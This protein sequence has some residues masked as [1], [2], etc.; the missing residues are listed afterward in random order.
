MT[1]TIVDQ[2]AEKLWMRIVAGELPAGARLRQDE[3]AA[4]FGSSHVPVRE[5]FRRLEAD[6]LVVSEPRRGV[7]VA[8]SDRA[9]HF[10]TLEMRAVLEGLAL[11]HA[12]TEYSPQDFSAVS[13]ADAACGRATTAEEWEEANRR[14]HVLLIAPCPLPALLRTVRR[15][16]MMSAL[17]ARALGGRQTGAFPRADRDH[18]AILTALQADDAELCATLLTRHIRRGHLTSGGGKSAAAGPGW[19][20]NR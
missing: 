13:E 3:I 15:L 10:E 20:R 16:Q 2:I 7:R 19:T 12:A 9:Q 18:K 17:S 5:A 1:P 8:Q 11:F 6:G 4:E 14:F